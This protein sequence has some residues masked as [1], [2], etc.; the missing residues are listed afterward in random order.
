MELILTVMVPVFGLIAIGYLTMRLQIVPDNADEVIG[1]FIFT[2]GVPIL[3][4]LTMFRADFGGAS[5][6][7]LWGAYFIGAF[8]TWA[9]AHFLVRW[10]YGR[11]ARSGVIAGVSAA[12]SN[13]I[14]IGIPLTQQ[15]YGEE[16]L[17][18]AL[19]LI[20]VHLALMML[21]STI[22]IDRAAVADGIADQAPSFSQTVMHVVRAVTRNPIVIGIF[23][24]LALRLTGWQL[25]GPIDSLFSQVASVS[26]PLALIVLGMGLK[27]HGIARNITVGVILAGLKLLVMPAIVFFVGRALGLP[28]TWLGVAVLIAA[29]PTGVNA[30]LLASSFRTGHAIAS[31][32]IVAS[33]LL[34]ILTTTFW[35][36]IVQFMA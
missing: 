1:D 19:L 21:V 8:A 13:T 27:R 6:F 9:M 31:N 26:G 20:S 29:C 2:V 36:L 16:G 30:Y 10:L 34:A 32:T 12:F 14:L 25:P 23:T 18:I 35:L 3:L 15:V 7:I 5:P 4:A 11:D 33:V 28:S 24:G 17:A 22:L